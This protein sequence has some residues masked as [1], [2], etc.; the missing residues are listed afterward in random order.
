VDLSAYPGLEFASGEVVRDTLDMRQPEVMNHWAKPDR[1]RAVGL[2]AASG[3]ITLPALS[4]SAIEFRTRSLP[5][6]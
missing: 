3:S 2:T 5:T 1:I 4:A 6:F